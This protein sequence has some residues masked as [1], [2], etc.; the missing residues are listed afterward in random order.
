MS[1]GARSV[2]KFNLITILVALAL[3]AAGAGA[4][5][6]AA[7]TPGRSPLDSLIAIESRVQWESAPAESAIAQAKRAGRPAFLDFYADWCAPCRWMDRAVYPDPLLGEVSEAVTMIR[8]DIDRP[9]GRK[10]ADR[11]GVFQ[12]PTLVYLAP[13]GKEKLRWPGPLSLRDTRLNLAQVA[14]PS[15]GR[16]AVEAARARKPHDAATQAEALDWYGRRGEVERVRAVVDTLERGLAGAPAAVPADAARLQLGLGKAEEIAG[17]YGRALVAYRRALAL[18]PDGALAWRAWLGASVCLEATGAGD[19]AIAAARE[20]LARRADAP[21]LAARVARL[22][23]ARRSPV[24]A[25]PPG[26]DD[27]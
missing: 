20:A 26:I 14:L 19:D 18:A 21:W 3:P 25:T 27:R 17:R 5:A 8:V 22:D 15:A 16:A 12:Y 9:P 4:A 10:L 23:L 6:A 2:P 13:D 7:T 11:M 1:G 24:L